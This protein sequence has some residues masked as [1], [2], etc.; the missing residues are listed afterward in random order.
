MSGCAP[1]SGLALVTSCEPS[2]HDRQPSVW[3]SALEG[4]LAI[5][6]L[7]LFLRARIPKV[8]LFV[9]G[10]NRAA[11]Y[12]YWILDAPAVNRRCHQQPHEVQRLSLLT[13]LTVKVPAAANSK[14]RTWRMR[15]H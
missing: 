15:H 14:M 3:A 12:T 7:L 10:G 13:L 2:L 9:G 6:M 1:S 4:F 5:N 8:E 11:Y